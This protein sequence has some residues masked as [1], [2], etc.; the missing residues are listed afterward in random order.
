VADGPSKLSDP[1]SQSA[2]LSADIK[3]RRVGSAERA[4][5]PRRVAR[6]HPNH[7]ITADIEE[8]VPKAFKAGPLIWRPRF[9]N[10][11]IN[12]G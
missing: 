4:S 2:G 7:D 9:F 12:L 1:S 10:A 8:R 3:L 5:C 11:P 6:Y